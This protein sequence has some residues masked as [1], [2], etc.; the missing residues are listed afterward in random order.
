VSE[1]NQ[2]IS[3]VERKRKQRKLLQL[4]YKVQLTTKLLKNVKGVGK[5][6]VWSFQANREHILQ[7]K[8]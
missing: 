2:V 1:Q 5:L 7:I 6:L 4:V 8:L 3:T